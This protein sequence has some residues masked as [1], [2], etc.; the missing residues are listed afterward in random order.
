MPAGFSLE[1]LDVQP[2]FINSQPHVVLFLSSLA[3]ILGRYSLSEPTTTSSPLK[4]LFSSKVLKLRLVYTNFSVSRV[5]L[6]SITNL[7]LEV[8]R[9]IKNYFKDINTHTLTHG[10]VWKDISTHHVIQCITTDIGAGYA[11]TSLLR[12]QNVL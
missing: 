11:K 1:V 2:C 4:L 6:G 3:E 9:D 12:N 5:K 10:I 8:G 7:W